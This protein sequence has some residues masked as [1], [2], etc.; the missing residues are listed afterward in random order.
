MVAGLCV[1][2]F[3]VKEPGKVVNA[4]P[5]TPLRELIKIIFKNDQL[6]FTA[7]SMSLFQ[8]GYLTT[9]SFGTY[10]FK[11]AYGNEDM[12]SVFALVLGLSQIA[13]LVIAP[14][15]GQ[16]LARGR[17]FAISIILM[18]IGYVIFFFSP[19]NMIFIGV[20]GVFIFVGQGFIQLLMLMFLAD[21]VDYGQWKLGKRNDSVT[22]SLQPF[23]NKSGG[24][25]AS[26]VVSLV[27]ILSGIKDAE[28][29]AEVTPGGL[30]MMKV[31]MLAF[32]L[33]CIIV[34]Y[35][36]YKRK[37][38]IDKAFYEKIQAELKARGEKI[39]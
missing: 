19:M 36:I 14:F 8:I 24:A 20:A 3:F 6:L 31:A 12:Y 7:V 35:V 21:S 32:P 33:V 26:G 34:C 5:A 1:T 17:F 28:T 29:A 37:Y 9:T 18:S 22:F 13:A 30:F 27:L 10:F 38:K 25:I 23:I 2:F 4:Q 15:I 11:Y 39:K 16:K